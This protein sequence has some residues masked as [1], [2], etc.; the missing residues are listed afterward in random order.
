MFAAWITPRKGAVLHPQDLSIDNASS[1][2][3]RLIKDVIIH[4]VKPV[5]M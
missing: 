4:Y 1:H 2:H 3:L 5:P